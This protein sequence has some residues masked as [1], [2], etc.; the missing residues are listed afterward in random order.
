MLRSG[1]RHDASLKT[2][3]SVKLPV[4]GRRPRNAPVMQCS[5]RFWVMEL[6]S[7]LLTYQN[8]RQKRNGL[9]AGVGAEAGSSGVRIW[10]RGPSRAKHIQLRWL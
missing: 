7:I 1:F 2:G 8:F 4:T 6:W 10:L 9:S 5:M 3:G